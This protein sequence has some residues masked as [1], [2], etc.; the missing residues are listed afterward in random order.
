M[1]VAA[2]VYSASMVRVATLLP[3]MFDGALDI[4]HSPRLRKYVL[5]LVV[6]NMDVVKIDFASR[7][8]AR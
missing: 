6:R 8:W 2:V 7:W 4:K 1:S 3:E 5:Q